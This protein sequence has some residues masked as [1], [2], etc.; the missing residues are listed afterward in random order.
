[1][2]SFF[3][4]ENPVFQ[5]LNKVCDMLLVSIAFILLCLPVVTIG[6]ACTA[7]YYAVVKVIRRERGYIFREFFR[8]FKMNFKRGA[9]IGVL[10]LIIFIVLG[11][12]LIYAWGLTEPESSKGSL[13]MGVFIGITFL[14]AGFS[15]YV[16]PILSRFDMTIKQLIKAA[17]YMSMRH[18]LFTIIMVAV[19]AAV[20]IIVYFFFPFI[21]IAPATA[22]LVNSLMMEKIFKKYMPASEGSGEETGKD[23]WYLE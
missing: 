12:D 15:V 7:L 10:L 1:M 11:F 20:V 4:L 19:N 3:N 6:P 5:I 9:I 17:T 13:L 21:F 23:E 2:S 8:S 16:F 14:V 18:I 22:T